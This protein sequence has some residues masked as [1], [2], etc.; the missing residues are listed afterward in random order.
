MIKLTIDHLNVLAEN[1]NTNAEY[2]TCFMNILEEVC[3]KNNF[4]FGAF[5]LKNN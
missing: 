3:D 1:F 5:R 4:P 2:K